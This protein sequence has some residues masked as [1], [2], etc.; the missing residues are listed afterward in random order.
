VPNSFVIPNESPWAE[1]LHGFP[2]GKILSKYISSEGYQD[3][4]IS[5]QL[6]KLGVTFESMREQNFDKIL[7]ALVAH[8]DFFGD[9]LV[10]R[11]YRIPSEAPW[12][13]IVWNLQLGNRVRNIM[14]GRAYAHSRYYERLRG[15]GFPMHLIK[16][17]AATKYMNTGSSATH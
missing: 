17:Y 9:M 16:S 13:P 3:D 10:P 6:E 5:A 2:L 4:T 12:P 11:Y 15:I 7:I 8:Y 14:H 1:S